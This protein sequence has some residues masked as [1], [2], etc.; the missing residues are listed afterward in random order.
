MNT[1]LV[2]GKNNDGLPVILDTIEAEEAYA[3]S[4]MMEGGNGYLH[5]YANG[6]TIAEFAPGEWS[7][8]KQIAT[9]NE[10]EA[11]PQKAYVLY[12]VPVLNISL[13]QQQPDK[14]FDSYV[15]GELSKDEVYQIVLDYLRAFQEVPGVMIDA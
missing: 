10:R 2:Y 3:T 15:G 12:R 9:D 5:F 14:L 4:G 13:A 1:Y 7:H 11:Q 8:F 6:Q